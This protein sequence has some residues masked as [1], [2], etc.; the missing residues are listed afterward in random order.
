MS[1]SKQAQWGMYAFSSQY[2]FITTKIVLMDVRTHYKQIILNVL[3]IDHL[4]FYGVIKYFVNYCFCSLV[5][6]SNTIM[7]QTIKMYIDLLTSQFCSIHP[8]KKLYLIFCNIFCIFFACP[9]VSKGLF[10]H[11]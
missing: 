3:P 5:S 10:W 11:W 7:H 6:V 1:G 2:Y 4:L 9:T 8:Q